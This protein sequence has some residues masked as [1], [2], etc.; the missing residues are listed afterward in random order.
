MTRAMAVP[1]PPTI[2]LVQAGDRGWRRGRTGAILRAEHGS[3]ETPS[4]DP[5]GSLPR[6]VSAPARGPTLAPGP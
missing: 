1:S 5:Q 6:L 2:G 3:G 4:S